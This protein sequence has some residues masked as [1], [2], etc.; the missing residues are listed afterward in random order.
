MKYLKP[1]GHPPLKFP[2]LI[3]W[4]Y[5]AT[6]SAYV[7]L[8]L[9]YSLIS[10]AFLVNFSGGNPVSSH[11]WPTVAEAGNPDAYGKAT[12]LV[13]WALN[14]WGMV[15]L[16]LASENVAMFI[17]MPWMGL[18]LIFWVITNVS[19]S[20]YDIDIEP[21]FY[22]WGYA[23]PLHHGKSSLPPLQFRR[24]VVCEVFKGGGRGL[25]FS[26]CSRA[27]QQADPVRSQAGDRAEFR[28]ADCLGRGEHGDIS[29]RVLLDA[30]EEHPW[31]ARVL[32]MRRKN[33]L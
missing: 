20:F 22:Y 23:W 8:S 28:R 33:R 10:L 26:L 19:T 6:L 17:G 30:V 3:L 15:A 2:Q 27:S 25:T 9:A 31:G 1:E 5:T 12:F 13:Y 7:F 21:R 29:R 24:G 16:G 14:F 11:I 18:W 32:G 4:R